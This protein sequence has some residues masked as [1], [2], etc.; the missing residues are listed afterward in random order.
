MHNK[1]DYLCTCFHCST[2]QAY[3]YL[4]RLQFRWEG[5]NRATLFLVFPVKYL[6]NRFPLFCVT[7]MTPDQK[8][9]GVPGRAWL[10]ILEKPPVISSGEMHGAVV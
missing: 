5:L 10:C 4:E 6:A 2:C 1:Y 3:N 7:W 8:P 9:L